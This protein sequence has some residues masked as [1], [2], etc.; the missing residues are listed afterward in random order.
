MTPS[1]VVIGIGNEFRGDDAVG[2]IAARRLTQHQPE[3]AHVVESSGEAL[4]LME[5]WQD[6]ER[7]IL[8]D[9]ATGIPP[10]EVRRY[11]AG[12]EPL[13]TDQFTTSTHAFSLANAIELARS[14]DR[15]PPSVIVY[16]IGG[17]AF[18]HGS[19]LSPD[20]ALGCEDALECIL[21]ELDVHQL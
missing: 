21:A 15:L 13:P 17:A 8:I 7:V 10:G 4:A 14:L 11:E 1:T 12:S 5:H 19:E 2:R 18:E 20:T 9:A 6:A 3:G 16:A